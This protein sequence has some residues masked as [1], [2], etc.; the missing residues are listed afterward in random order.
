[1][2][3]SLLLTILLLGNGCEPFVVEFPDLSIPKNFQASNVDPN[4]KLYQ[5]GEIKVLT[6]KV[7]CPKYCP[8]V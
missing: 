2:R 5:G 4:S 8:K 3:T 1:M 6:W 7:A